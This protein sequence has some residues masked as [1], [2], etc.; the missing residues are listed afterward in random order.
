MLVIVVA[1]CEISRYFWQD[2][3]TDFQVLKHGITKGK[4]QAQSTQALPIRRCH[5]EVIGG[6]QRSGGRRGRQKSQYAVRG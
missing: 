5:A 3:A 1:K 2:L 6:W 4:Y